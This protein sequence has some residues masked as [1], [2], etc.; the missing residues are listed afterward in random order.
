MK[1]I[2][3][4]LFILFSVNSFANNILDI[5]NKIQEAK[6]QNKELMIF[7][8]IPDCPYCE[9]MLNENFKNNTITTL[10]DKNFILVDIYTANKVD[11]VFKDFKGSPKEFAKHIK[12]TAYPATLFMDENS[13]IIYSAIGYRNVQE[14]IHELKYIITKSYKQMPLDEFVVKMEIEDEL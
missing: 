6:K 3:S 14:Y 12:A 9:A 10:I 8:H 1:Y 11:I 13:N 2:F 5:D 7:F 4:F